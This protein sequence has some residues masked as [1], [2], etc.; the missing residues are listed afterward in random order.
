[1]SSLLEEL[2]AVRDTAIDYYYIEFVKNLKEIIRTD[3]YKQVF[4]VDT[5]YPIKIDKQIKER[6]IKEGVF[7]KYDNDKFYV[8]LP[9]RA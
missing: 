7:V 5:N 4:A 6:L 2:I 9:P 8:T 1:M 3:P